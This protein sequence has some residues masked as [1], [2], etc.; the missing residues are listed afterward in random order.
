MS[1]RDDIRH[2][3]GQWDPAGRISDH[4]AER[5]M[6]SVRRGV[7]AAAAEE[8]PRSVVPMRWALA[9]AALFLVVV[10]LAPIARKSRPVTSP[11]VDQL[12]SRQTE[13]IHTVL[14]ASNG[15]RIY[16]STKP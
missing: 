10:L 16:W 6:Q 7:L 15:T 1:E 12:A 5:R 11:V 14:V 8:G 3:L 2:A 4:E 9:A 13:P